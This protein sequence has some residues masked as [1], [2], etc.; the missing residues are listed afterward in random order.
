M[1][2]T[3]VEYACQHCGA[4]SPKW[5]GKCPECG[6]FN[7]LV[8][9]A[10]RPVAEEGS[11]RPLL[12]SEERPLPITDVRSVERPRLVVGLGEF[13]RVLG[14]G[15]VV[16][17][18]SLI[19][20][21]PG[22]GK[23]TLIL[24]VCQK[25][26]AQGHRVLYASSEESLTQT[27]LRAERLGVD[28][29]NLFVVSETSVEVL[30]RHLEE[31]RPAFA[32]V[33]SIQMIYRPEI[34][35]APGTVAQVRECAAELTYLAKRLGISLFIVGH[36]TK[37]GAIA[38]P[39]TLEH[40]VDAVFYFE[41]DRFQTFRLLRSVKNRFGSTHEIGIFEMASR[42][43]AE[44]ANPSE[45]FLAQD[46]GA[47][48]GSAITPSLIGSRTLLVEI[49]AL[50][51]PSFYPENVARRVSGVDRDRLMLLLA[52]LARRC[53]FSVAGEDVF[54][55]A[56]GG[57]RIDEPA[58]DLAV[59]TALASSFLN[60]PVAERTV[61]FGEV[62]LSGEVRGV[63]QA[64]AR[65]A[66]ARRLGFARAL[67]PRANARG[68]GDVEGLQIVPVSHLDEAFVQAHLR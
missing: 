4:R 33:D 21:D 27:K 9:E 14:G 41:G 44:V 25:I 26:A 2:K 61:V 35:S 65:A 42:G 24:Q 53:G 34:P 52:V 62:G 17:S 28:S 43:L 63:A 37:E 46:R 19:G 13:D 67:V 40:V 64:A 50:T 36:V 1:A 32:V 54:V 51:T 8:E 59:A 18:V 39:R 56:V 10:V 47:K 48:E 55:N 20:G 45:L 57:V 38:G 58:A 30:R 31:L 7:S 60:R 16:G 11:R 66:E 12:A 68:L 5:L 49:Q 23:S 22:I 29:P 6:E 3:R 15:I